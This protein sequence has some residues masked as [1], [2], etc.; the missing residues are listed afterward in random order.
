MS[1]LKK[2]LVV[3]ENESAILELT[4][5]AAFLGEH[6]ELIYAGNQDMAWNAEIAYYAGDLQDASFLSYTSAILSVVNETQ[7]SLIMTEATK[8]GRHLAAAIATAFNSSVLTDALEISVEENTVVSTRMVYGGA[9]AK[10]EKSLGGIAVTCVG[11]GV[12]EAKQIKKTKNISPLNMGESKIRLLERRG[13]AVKTVNLSAAKC[14]VGVGR[15]FGSAENVDIAKRFAEALG[16]EVGCSRPVGEEEKWL[17]K[18]TYLGISGVMIKPD[19]YIACGISGQV[20]HMTGVNQAKTIIA[21]NKDKGA[22][23]FEKCDYGIVGDLKKIL[24]ALTDKIK[25]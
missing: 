18:E 5:G 13:K 16:G 9:A 22:P 24:P 10:K 17:P 19:V 1:Q 21:I 8:N 11:A 7:P 23:I 12:F 14:V 15:G 2:V 6:T 3:A 20:Q 25:G 4:A